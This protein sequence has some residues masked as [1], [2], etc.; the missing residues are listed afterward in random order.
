LRELAL[1]FIALTYGRLPAIF[2]PAYNP[3]ENP[4]KRCIYIAAILLAILPLGG[5]AG[6]KIQSPS[7]TLA[8]IEVIEAGLIEQRL[9]FKLRI[10]NPNDVEIPISG[11]SFEVE[12]NG[13]PF[14]K[15]VSNKPI[16]LPRLSEAVLDVTAVTGFAGILRQI[17]ALSRGNLDAISYRIKGRLATGYSYGLNFDE[18]GKL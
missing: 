8:G 7:V 1:K 2:V 14:A 17:G 10:L 16:T 12:L 4:M 13:E 9:A 15:G 11:L 18:R 3:L 5:C 6:M